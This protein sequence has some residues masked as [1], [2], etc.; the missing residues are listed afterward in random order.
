[1]RFFKKSITQAQ[2]V[3]DQVACYTQVHHKSGRTLYEHMIFEQ[4]YLTLLDEGHLQPKQLAEPLLAVL[5]VFAQSFRKK[6][7]NLYMSAVPHCKEYV[8][9]DSSVCDTW[10]ITPTNIEV[11][12]SELQFRLHSMSV[13]LHPAGSEANRHVDV[14]GTCAEVDPNHA[15]I[16]ASL[17]LT[18]SPR[19]KSQK[20]EVSVFFFGLKQ[21]I[22][23]FSEAYYSMPADTEHQF[24]TKHDKV[25]FRF[26][27]VLCSGKEK[28]SAQTGDSPFLGAVKTCT[29]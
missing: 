13:M 24:K 20:Y 8:D 14:K 19:G 22:D 16:I 5:R 21:D 27:G 3:K 10:G 15:I 28:T 1:M 6:Q 12:E 23:M 4:K 9:V 26:G 2:R 25:T 29:G 7:Q 17:R 18:D 11:I